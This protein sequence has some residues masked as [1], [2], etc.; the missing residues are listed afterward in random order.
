MKKIYL[1]LVAFSLIGGIFAQYNVNLVGQFSGALSPIKKSQLK[2]NPGDTTF[3]TAPAASQTCASNASK[4]KLYTLS[5][6][7]GYA[8][9]TNS[10]KFTE[11]AQRF[12]YT[13]GGWAFA[14]FIP[15]Y[16]DA[17]GSATV[18]FYSIDGSTGAPNSLLG[19]TLAVPLDTMTKPGYILFFTPD[20]IQIPASG[21][22]SSLV[23]PTVTTDT[24]ACYSSAISCVATNDLSWFKRNNTWYKFS[25]A[26]NGLNVQWDLMME[27]VVTIVSG[28][29]HQS[30]HDMF[31]L[32]NAS[33]NPAKDRTLIGYTLPVSAKVNFT[34]TDMT[35]REVFAKDFGF[36]ASGLHSIDLDISN[37][38]SG[39]YYYSIKTDN[40]FLTK[41]MI[42]NK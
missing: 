41:K 2:K 22:F 3:L 9:G 40:G 17:K 7:G 25:D 37:F 15:V 35:G 39:L 32:T 13:L 10:A 5:N 33:P 6:N 8:T 27:P 11:V 24:L 12:D 19:T 28:V 16:A 18:K 42:V 34:V 36:M 20:Y 26:T 38:N 30:N 31:Y 29:S 23:L 4:Y 14:I 1:F 21:F